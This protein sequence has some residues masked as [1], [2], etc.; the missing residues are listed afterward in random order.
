MT[1]RLTVWQL[2]VRVTVCSI[3]H[4][5]FNFTSTYCNVEWKW[6]I[7]FFLLFF[8]FLKSKFLCVE[9]KEISEV[10]LKHLLPCNLMKNQVQVIRPQ[11]CVFFFKLYGIISC[12]KFLNVI[13]C[14]AEKMIHQ[15][16]PRS[17]LVHQFQC[18]N[19]KAL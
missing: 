1:D 5:R 4:D 8:Y 10:C 2:I 19:F 16:L 13:H 6:V 3:A 11:L 15:P 14:Y 18:L 17:T 12:S 9:L 7:C